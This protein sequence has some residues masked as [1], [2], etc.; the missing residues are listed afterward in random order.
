M[1]FP[2]KKLKKY[3]IAI[4]INVELN[5]FQVNLGPVVGTEGVFECNTPNRN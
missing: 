4:M 1:D 2:M 5:L 3:G